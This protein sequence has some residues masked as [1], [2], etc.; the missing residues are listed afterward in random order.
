[1]KNKTSTRSKKQT[2]EEIALGIPCGIE[3]TNKALSDAINNMSNTE[4]IDFYIDLISR[5]IKNTIKDGKDQCLKNK[6]V[7]ALRGVPMNTLFAEKEI[8]SDQLLF[9]LSV[10]VG[11][12]HAIKG[13]YGNTQ[14]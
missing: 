1:M 11:S 8:K 2:K 10:F 5:V 12:E 4:L 6:I 7:L 9:L 13:N 3:A 14:Y